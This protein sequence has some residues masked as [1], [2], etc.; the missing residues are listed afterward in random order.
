MK[1]QVLLKWI[2]LA[3]Y[4]DV[5]RP[6]WLWCVTVKDNKVVLGGERAT[7]CS[8]DRSMFARLTKWFSS[9]TQEAMGTRPLVEPG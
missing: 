4:A 9:G 5:T 8:C 2:Q 1:A 6:G 3:G 7:G